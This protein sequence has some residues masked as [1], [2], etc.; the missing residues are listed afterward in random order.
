MRIVQGRTLSFVSL[1]AVLVA[2]SA[3]AQLDPNSALL[4]NPSGNSVRESGLESGRYQVRQK[5]E[6]AN[7]S[8]RSQAVEESTD[9]Q[10]AVPSEPLTYSVPSAPPAASTAAPRVQVKP[11]PESKPEE[12]VAM[13]PAAAPLNDRRRDPLLEIHL[14]PGYVYTNSD[15]SYTFRR[16]TTAAPTASAS[17]VVWLQPSFGLQASYMTTLGGNVGDSPNNTHDIAATQEWM[18]LGIRTKKNFGSTLMSPLMTFGLDYS[19]YEFKVPEK[20]FTRNRLASRG[21]KLSLDA[22][23]PSSEGH[24]WTLG[25]SFLPKLAHSEGRT[26]AKFE[27]GAGVEANALGVSVGG[28]IRFQQ[29][30]AMFWKLIYTLEKAQYTGS[31]TVADPLLGVQPSGVSVTNTSTFLQ[32]GY[33][34]SN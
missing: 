9:P 30:D 34:W 22:E 17:A 8:R 21:V 7:P 19:N 2:S 6:V 5:K 10:M 33:T 12:R 13:V 14:A 25:F 26:D 3:H 4:L 18:T 20:A 27:T 32:F 16:Y 28:K 31:A 15:S 11:S 23:L 29:S 24:A 1:L